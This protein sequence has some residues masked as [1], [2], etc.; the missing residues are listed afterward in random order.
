[1]Q[2]MHWLKQCAIL[3]SKQL[4]HLHSGKNFKV[5]QRNGACYFDRQ[6]FEFSALCSVH[7]NPDCFS[8][9]QRYKIEQMGR[10]PKKVVLK[11][12]NAV[13]AIYSINAEPESSANTSQKRSGP[14]MLSSAEKPMTQSSP[15][16]KVIR[17]YEKR[18]AAR[19]CKVMNNLNHILLKTINFRQIFLCLYHSAVSYINSLIF[20]IMYTWIYDR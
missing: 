11:N 9:R 8:F 16:K 1:M 4:C 5:N 2:D 20:I 12:E 15:P 3:H 14:Q 19:V 7:F 6:N 10:K 18:E 13:P 17:C